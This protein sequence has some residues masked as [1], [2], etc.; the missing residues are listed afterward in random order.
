LVTT[1]K[2]GPPKSPHP[3]LDFSAISLFLAPAGS[4]KVNQAKSG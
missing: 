1:E 3:I 2:R 4:I